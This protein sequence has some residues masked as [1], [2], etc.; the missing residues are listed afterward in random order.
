MKALPL[1]LLG[2]DIRFF[3]VPH[4]NMASACLYIFVCKS[5]PVAAFSASIFQVS[6]SARNWPSSSVL[7]QLSGRNQNTKSISSMPINFLRTRVKCFAFNWL[8]WYLPM[9][10]TETRNSITIIY[11]TKS[12]SASDDNLAKLIFPFRKL[13]WLQWILKAIGVCN[14]HHL[15]LVLNKPYEFSYVRFGYRGIIISK[16]AISTAVLRYA[17]CWIADSTLFNKLDVSCGDDASQ[18]G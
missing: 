3:D 14:I 16:S 4:M 6:L 11:I 9:P 8:T 17:R 5:I 15:Y 7:L 18:I 13:K 10:K 2:P 12:H 1:E